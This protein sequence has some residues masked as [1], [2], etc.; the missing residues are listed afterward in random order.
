MHRVFESFVQI[1]NLMPPNVSLIKYQCDDGDGY[2]SIGNSV[3][4]LGD[5]LDFGQLFKALGNS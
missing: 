5:L 1:P 2:F 3:T 4:R